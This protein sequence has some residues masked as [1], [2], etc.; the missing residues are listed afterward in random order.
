MLFII[1]SSILFG[2]F[3]FSL[4]KYFQWFFYHKDVN[5]KRWFII[6]LLLATIGS[7]TILMFIVNSIDFSGST[8]SFFLSRQTDVLLHIYLGLMF[9][10]TFVEGVKLSK[11]GIDPNDDYITKYFLG[12]SFIKFISIILFISYMTILTI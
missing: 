7:Y 2:L 9:A 8:V 1:I 12:F 6:S 11:M 10:S 5:I 3:L 4:F